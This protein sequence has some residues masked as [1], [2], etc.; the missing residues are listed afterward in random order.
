MEIKFTSH[1]KKKDKVFKFFIPDA[2]N[3]L[4]FKQARKLAELNTKYDK[5]TAI[6]H[7]F[8]WL[9]DF[10]IVRGTTMIYRDEFG[11]TFSCWYF[12]KHIHKWLIPEFSISA[13]SNALEKW[14]FNGDEAPNSQLHVSIFKPFKAEKH[15]FFPPADII[16]NLTYEQYTYADSHFQNFMN[17]KEPKELDSFIAAL[18]CVDNQFNPKTYLNY[19]HIF[20]K[21]SFYDKL[22]H[23]WFFIGCRKVLSYIFFNLVKA[24][25]NNP[26]TKS[27]PI[28]SWMKLTSGMTKSPAE[29]DLTKKQLAWDVFAWLDSEIKNFNKHKK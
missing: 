28:L 19:V 21:R 26:D 25:D 8:C 14:I 2:W 5:Q 4:S 13:I 3:D 6:I 17:K 15:H 12:R 27:D 20:K 18:Y 1:N 24:S 10:H 22:V 16:S 29:I 9:N 23:L 7:F 11:S